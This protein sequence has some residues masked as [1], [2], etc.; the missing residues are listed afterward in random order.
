MDPV[1]DDHGLAPSRP[2]ELLGVRRRVWDGERP[3]GLVWCCSDL[4]QLPETVLGTQPGELLVL[5][6]S[7]TV[8]AGAMLSDVAWA[9]RQHELSHVFVVAHAGCRMLSAALGRS[10]STGPLAAQLDRLGLF[11]G[12][13]SDAV[14]R[15]LA[16]V[17]SEGLR[18]ELARRGVRS[19]VLA[20]FADEHGRLVPLRDTRSERIGVA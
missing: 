16:Q 2:L 13:E 7:S 11:A 1:F 20:T 19:E 6:G 17:A 14:S 10:G 18:V 15:T 12:C 3:W 5:Q 4:R 9:A 8:P